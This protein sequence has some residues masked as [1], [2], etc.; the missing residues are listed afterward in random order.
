MSDSPRQELDY[1]P[2][3]AAMQMID[4]ILLYQIEEHPM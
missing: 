2:D 4:L 1:E 3:R